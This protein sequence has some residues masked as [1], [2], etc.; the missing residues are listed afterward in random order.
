MKTQFNFQSQHP[1]IID[2]Y[3]WKRTKIPIEWAECDDS[4]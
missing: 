1:Y 3:L 4:Y 2:I